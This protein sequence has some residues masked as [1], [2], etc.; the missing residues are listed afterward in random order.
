MGTP[1]FGGSCARTFFEPHR[2]EIRWAGSFVRK[3]DANPR[4]QAVREPTHQDLD[5]TETRNAYRGYSIRQLWASGE[6]VPKCHPVGAAF[7]SMIDFKS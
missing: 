6:S 7:W 5:A 2:G 1:D 4:R 3:P